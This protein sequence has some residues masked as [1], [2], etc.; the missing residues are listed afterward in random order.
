MDIGDRI[1]ILGCSGSGKSTFAR[2]LQGIT[3][4]PLIHLDNLWWRANGTHVSRE[5]FDRALA[6]ALAG[7]RWIIDG[8]FRRTYAARFR[9]CDTVFFLDYDEET[10]LAGIEARIGIPR[11]DMPWTETRPDPELA[12]M[13][14]RYRGENRPEIYALLKRYPGKRAFIFKTRADADRWMLERLT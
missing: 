9:A 13:V 14:R 2:R 5:A 1:I 12:E 8:D 6:A 11:P 4:L 7:E 10:C 3:G